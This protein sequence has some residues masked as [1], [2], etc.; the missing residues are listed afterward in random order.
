MTF[1]DGSALT[2]TTALYNPP[3]GNNFHG[4]GVT[5]V[6]QAG[7]NDDFTTL[8]IAEL[9]KLIANQNTNNAI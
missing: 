5:P 4:L 7:E 8:A 1:K 2:L 3:S 6:V 9:N